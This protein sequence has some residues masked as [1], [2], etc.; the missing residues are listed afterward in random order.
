MQLKDKGKTSKQRKQNWS[1]WGCT[2][3][4][5]GQGGELAATI[6]SFLLQPRVRPEGWA[7]AP[8]PRSRALREGWGR[9]RLERRG[10][11][12]ARSARDLNFSEELSTS[13]EV[14]LRGSFLGWLCSLVGHSAGPGDGGRPGLYSKWRE[15]SG[16]CAPGPGGDWR[17]GPRAAGPGGPRLAA[18]RPRAYG[19]LTGEQLPCLA[20]GPAVGDTTKSPSGFQGPKCLTSAPARLRVGCWTAELRPHWRCPGGKWWKVFYSMPPCAASLQPS[21]RWFPSVHSRIFC[22]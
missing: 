3:R 14:K 13:A 10:R 11:G 16:A 5:P 18:R 4:P 15:D 17:A 1:F 2:V 19:H 21:K 12:G 7:T 22:C 20:R 9:A 6:L 8:A